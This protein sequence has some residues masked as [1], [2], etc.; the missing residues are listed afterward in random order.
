MAFWVDT[1]SRQGIYN[2][3][4]TP[5]PTMAVY[6]LCVER[7][8]YDVYKSLMEIDYSAGAGRAAG[9]GMFAGSVD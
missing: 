1:A 4:V 7:G 8:K 9:L 6:R 5:F 2:A 3:D